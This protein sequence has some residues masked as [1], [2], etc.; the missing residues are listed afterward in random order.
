MAAIPISSLPSA[1]SAELTDE[2]PV[3]QSGT[4]YKE[5]W[6]QV[7]DLM[8]ENI[9]QLTGITGVIK[10]PSAIQDVNGHNVVSFFSIDTGANNWLEIGNGADSD[11]T[12]SS[13]STINSD[14][15]MSFYTK[16]N[17]SFA[18]VC[19]TGTLANDPIYI[20]PN[21]LSGNAGTFIINTLSA[22]R[23]WHFPDLTGDVLIASQSSTG[24][25]TN[26]TNQIGFQ[27][28]LLNDVANVTGNGTTYNLGG[29]TSIYDNGN[30]FDDT[31][32]IFTAPVAGTYLISLI[33]QMYN[34]TAAANASFCTM[35]VL[36]S[37][38]PQGSHVFDQSNWGSVCNQATNVITLQANFLATFNEGDQF[39]VF[40]TESGTGAD[41][42]GISGGIDVT[43]ISGRLLI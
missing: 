3:N 29:L 39:L 15:A 9:T 43:N 25:I 34:I 17:A 14:V 30:C 38:S 26:N 22:F 21:G 11:A 1:T 5:T 40:I 23:S 18:F 33:A 37:S 36:G 20:F 28:Y 6:S 12:L 10:A 35:A 19:G 7:R 13:K 4:T 2:V 27:S 16:G 41:T 24:A 32:G 42:I 31:T 8:E